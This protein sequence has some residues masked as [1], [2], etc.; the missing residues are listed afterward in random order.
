LENEKNEIK[1]L[2]A[3]GSKK[4]GFVIYVYSGVEVKFPFA[5]GA[6]ETQ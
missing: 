3:E 4:N 6:T 5:N 1:K 2:K